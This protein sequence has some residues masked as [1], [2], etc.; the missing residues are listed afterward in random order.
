MNKPI[1]IV[2]GVLLIALGIVA[3]S[4]LFYVRETQ[5]TLVVQFGEPQRVVTD[6]GLHFK[7]PIVQQVI[8][9]ERRLLDF[10]A[11]TQEIPTIDQRQVLVDAYARYRIT[12]PLRFFQSVNNEARMNDQLASIIN[13]ALRDSLGRTTQVALLSPQRA[14]LMRD[15][16]TQVAEQSRGF[17]IEIVDV[18]LKRVDLP[19]ANSQAIYARMQTQREQEARKIRA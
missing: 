17:G 11:V 14:Q 3:Y 2:A 19:E 13:R 8:S 1:S 5:Q 10:D 6:P 4:G 16:T 9:F 7:I 18:R 12:D 15:F